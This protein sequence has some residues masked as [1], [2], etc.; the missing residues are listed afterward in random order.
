MKNKFREKAVNMSNT[1]LAL[2][3]AATTCFVGCKDKTETVETEKGTAKVIND[4]EYVEVNEK[5]MYSFDKVQLGGDKS[6]SGEEGDKTTNK[7]EIKPAKL[8]KPLYSEE[9]IN[10]LKDSLAF[11]GDSVGDYGYNA[12]YRTI[13]GGLVLIDKDQALE[14]VEKSEGIYSINKE[15]TIEGTSRY[16]LTNESGKRTLIFTEQE[17]LKEFAEA[18][19]TGYE[20]LEADQ[21]GAIINGVSFA[22]LTSPITVACVDKDQQ[23]VEFQQIMDAL[24]EHIQSLG[25]NEGAITYEIKDGYAEVTREKYINDNGVIS[26]EKLIITLPFGDKGATYY[27]PDFDV[28]VPYTY[29]E[30]DIIYISITTLSMLLGI[31]VFEGAYMVPSTET[32]LE[33]VIYVSTYEDSYYDVYMQKEI[34]VRPASGESSGEIS[35]TSESEFKYNEENVVIYEEPEQAGSYGLDVELTAKFG[36]DIPVLTGSAEEK[37]DQ[38]RVLF[39][40]QYPGIPF[41][42]GGGGVIMDCTGANWDMSV[43]ECQAKL[44]E[45]LGPGKDLMS[46]TVQEAYPVMEWLAVVNWDAGNRIINMTSHTF[47]ETTGGG[48]G[49]IWFS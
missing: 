40:Q 11:N 27:D 29:E 35:F 5:N 2:T 26:T 45:I 48:G 31:D 36:F 13:D 39:E 19:A 34:E 17:D 47:V 16:V 6:N 28:I 21:K 46:L 49:Q 37:A 44:D 25:F 4:K 9:Q 20:Q 38:L 8:F 22:P 23:F 43:E 18:I 10:K 33:D 41:T 1:A 7:A 30:N 32:T 15:E 3:L 42:S 12:I 24:S 14:L